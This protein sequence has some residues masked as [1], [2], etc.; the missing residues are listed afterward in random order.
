MLQS[1]LFLVN[2]VVIRTNSL[3]CDLEVESGNNKVKHYGEEVFEEVTYKSYQGWNNVTV[4]GYNCS[5]SEEEGM[6][7][8]GVKFVSNRYSAT[9]EMRDYWGT[10]LNKKLGSESF[11]GD[12]VFYY[13]DSHPAMPYEPGQHAN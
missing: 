2:V 5:I 13:F 11:E 1:N 7:E 10:A 12:R 8:F 9:A 6:T 4:C 3:T